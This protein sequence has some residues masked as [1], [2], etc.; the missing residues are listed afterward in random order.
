MRPVG[1]T[2]FPASRAGEGPFASMTFGYPRRPWYRRWLVPPLLWRLD[3]VLVTRFPLVWRTKAIFF[4]VGSTVVANAVLY[5]WGSRTPVALASIPD[6]ASVQAWL[7]V[8]SFWVLALWAYVQLRRPIHEMERRRYARLTALHFFCFLT[9]FANP[10]AYALPVVG[11]IAALVPDDAHE[12][13]YAFLKQN[14]FVPCLQQ[15]WLYDNHETVERAL[16]V[17]GYPSVE[18]PPG[19][20]GLGY[21]C[22]DV[23][24]RTGVSAYDNVPGIQ[25]RVGSVQ[26][27]KVFVRNGAWSY[28]NREA[29]LR[30]Y[31]PLA[32]LLSVLLTLGVCGRQR[33]T[34]SLGHYRGRFL[35]LPR[36][37]LPLPR[38]VRR[39]E[40]HLLT[41]N[42]LVWSSRAPSVLFYAGVICGGAV[43]L[44]LLPVVGGFVPRDPAALV[45]LGGMIL[46][47]LW[48]VSQFGVAL[49]GAD[50]KRNYVALLCAMGLWGM[51][52]IL[53]G[54]TAG[55]V[56]HKW[57][58]SLGTLGALL[59]LALTVVTGR[60]GLRFG[61]KTFWIAVG[62]GYLG[63]TT[64]LYLAFIGLV[65]L[66]AAGRMAIVGV[67]LA[68]PLVGWALRRRR[69]RPVSFV[70]AVTAIVWVTLAP[71][72]ATVASIAIV[73]GAGIRSG[74]V[75]TLAG[76]LVGSGLL[77]LL[78]LP[79][80]RTLLRYRYGPAAS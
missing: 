80:L 25:G 11:R 48:G 30:Y 61:L 5:L 52:C 41:T 36:I 66:S 72:M 2:V 59:P 57:G 79:P 27:A 74:G 67:A 60:F 23:L 42:P 32:L 15:D 29:G 45:S 71:A 47:G 13:S 77:L 26:E 31:A 28:A 64:L 51:L 50:P 7:R 37:S 6:V 62:I 53:L 35:T 24:A 12:E 3:R 9:A 4:L 46:A 39:I 55:L 1:A 75:G 40:S 78:V 8:V 19:G 33:A 58:E 18:L 76:V 14:V 56:S 69:G 54:L 43:A 20:R 10:V 16:A 21:G 34:R 65:L 68:V 22:A 70:K 73:S 44:A 38:W 63:G 49:P 17:Y